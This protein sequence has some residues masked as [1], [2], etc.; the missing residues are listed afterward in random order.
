MC[1]A[2][3]PPTVS[4]LRTVTCIF[5]FFRP[6]P[7]FLYNL[8]QWVMFNSYSVFL[9]GIM[10]TFIWF[11]GL[12]RKLGNWAFKFLWCSSTNKSENYVRRSQEFASFGYRKY[13]WFGNKVG[14]GRWALENNWFFLLFFFV[15]SL[16]L[17]P[18]PFLNGLTGKPVMVKLKWGMEY[19]GYLVSVDGYM[20]MQVS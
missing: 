4:C 2:L 6:L 3:S 16:P 13:W 10:S 12:K 19:K 15:Q 9:K 5:F 17:N 14:G 20:N 8:K 18:K 1:F 7:L 11:D